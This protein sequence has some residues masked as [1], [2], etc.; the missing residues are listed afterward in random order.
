MA[1]TTY[2]TTPTILG[3]AA[4]A[5][6]KVAVLAGFAGRSMP[7][8]GSSSFYYGVFDKLQVAIV[9]PGGSTTLQSTGLTFPAGDSP[10]GR[11]NPAGGGAISSLTSGNIAVLTWGGTSGNYD[12]TILNGDGSVNTAAFKVG[13]AAGTG[14]TG[15][16]APYNPVGTIAAMP[17]G[18]YV[19]AWSAN[20]IQQTY[21]QIYNSANQPDGSQITVASVTTSSTFW[22]GS[23]AVD[24]QGDIIL[25]FGAGDVYHNGT[26]KVYNSSGQLVGSGTTQES[27]AAPVFVGVAGGGF[28]TVSYQPSGPW[29]TSSGYPGFN[30]V[31]QSVSSTGVISNVATVANADTTDHYAPSVTDIAINAAGELVFKEAGHAAYDTLSG[32]TLT[33]DAISPSAPGVAFSTSPT[34]NEL[35]GSNEIIGA[36]VSGTSIVGESLIAPLC[37]LRG[38]EILTPRGPA[39]IEELCIG[40]EVV[41]HFGGISRIKW[42]GRQSYDRRFAMRNPAKIPVRIAAGALAEGQPRRDLFVSP[43]H[44]VLIGG[45]LVLAQLLVNGVTITQGDAPE[46]IDYVHIELDSHDCVLAEGCWSETYADAPGMRAQYHNADE[47]HQRYP[48]HLPAAELILCAPRP[49]EGVALEIALA[50]VV[51]RAA[52]KIEPGALLGYVEAIADDGTVTG[53]AI[54][55]MHDH[56]PVMLEAVVAG[57]VVGRAL[58][59]QDRQDVAD[60]GYATSRCGFTLQMETGAAAQDVTV[61]RVTD[62]AVLAALPELLMR[63]VA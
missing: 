18:G 63:Q 36:A 50:P 37:F 22:N 49:Q 1:T 7:Y 12:I 42:L 15:G 23:L 61:R 55:Q 13:N 53:W 54:D 11:G 26:Y 8:A 28:E 51:E 62:G 32:T 60:A 5:N 9:G 10:D 6:G 40:D 21:M 35:S 19:V 58:A 14:S 24:S 48:D 39:K 59:S 52:A 29:N 56:L 17:G 30:L 20:D 4:M 46:R 34:G 25:G 57:N 41:T 38:T 16:S 44:S 45:Q 33:R 3:T 2:T 27:Q 43:G 47:F 31:V